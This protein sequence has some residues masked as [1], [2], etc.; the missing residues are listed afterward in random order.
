MLV[1]ASSTEV[2]RIS[3]TGHNPTAQQT[4]TYPCTPPHDNTCQYHIT[5]QLAQPCWSALLLIQA[6]HTANIP[7]HPRKRTISVRGRRIPTL[8][9][10]AATGLQVG[11]RMHLGSKPSLLAALNA[12]AAD[13]HAHV[14]NCRRA[15]TRTVQGSLHAGSRTR[16]RTQTSNRAGGVGR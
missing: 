2:A 7:R 4:S 8:L 6:T 14:Y 9:Q 5:P 13:L 3:T 11:K 16:D 10:S 15:P 1:R 12:H